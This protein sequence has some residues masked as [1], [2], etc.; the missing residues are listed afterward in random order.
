MAGKKQGG[1][2]MAGNSVGQV[3]SKSRQAI[4]SLDRG[5]HGALI[6]K[7]HQI[8]AA[9]GALNPELENLSQVCE[10]IHPKTGWGGAGTRHATWAPKPRELEISRLPRTTWLLGAGQVIWPHPGLGK[11][12]AGDQGFMVR[13]SV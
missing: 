4:Q 7:R 10:R 8:R 13:G 1:E 12:V 5:E 2:G 11:E 3:Q 6:G 9:A